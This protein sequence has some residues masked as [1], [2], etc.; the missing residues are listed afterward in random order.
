M[1]GSRGL[2]VYIQWSFVDGQPSIRVPE[3]SNDILYNIVKTF[4]L[5]C[6]YFN[7]FNATPLGTSGGIF[8]V[9]LAG[10]HYPLKGGVEIKNKEGIKNGLP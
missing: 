8:Y 9:H 2:Y 7:L 6:K 4:T 5:A 3:Y 1:D 10:L